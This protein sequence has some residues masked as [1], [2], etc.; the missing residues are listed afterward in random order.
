[1]FR[2]L[3]FVGF[4]LVLPAG[5]KRNDAKLVDVQRHV[6]DNE[7]ESGENSTKDTVSVCNRCFGNL[8]DPGNPRFACAYSYKLVTKKGTVKKDWFYDADDIGFYHLVGMEQVKCEDSVDRMTGL[9]GCGG[10]CS[11]KQWRK[12]CRTVNT[13]EVRAVD[14]PEGLPDHLA[15]DGSSS[16]DAE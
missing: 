8:A 10:C 3:F 14:T 15:S 12:S 4:A 13:K 16:E 9:S 1:M 2:F 5:A 11:N 6:A 7:G